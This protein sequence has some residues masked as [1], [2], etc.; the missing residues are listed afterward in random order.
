MR[1]CRCAAVSDAHR[2]DFELVGFEGALGLG[3]ERTARRDCAEHRGGRGA[4]EACDV[5]RCVF[6]SNP[7]TDFRA[8]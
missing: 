4:G 8:N 7:I 2:R 5:L 6:R 1:S 3:G